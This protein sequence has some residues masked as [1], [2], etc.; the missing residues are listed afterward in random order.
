MKKLISFF[1]IA[2][3]FVSC[4]KDEEKPT[5]C[6]TYQLKNT[7]SISAEL[8]KDTV[9]F[10]NC[11]ENATRYKWDFGDGTTSTEENPVHLYEE[12]MP[13]L[14]SLT[15]YNG[16]NSSVLTDTIWD[17][18]IVFKP[19]IYLYPEKTLELCVNLNFPKGGHVVSSIPEYN[20]GWCIS[21][22]PSGQIDNE[23]G[24][25][26]Y[27]SA[28]PNI[29]QN[30]E[31]WIISQT[32]LSNFFNK[33]MQV[34]GFNSNEINDFIEYWIPLLN[35]AKTYAVYPQMNYTIDRVIELEFSVKPKNVNRLFYVIKGVNEEFMLNE[36]EIVSFNKNGFYVNEWG[37]VL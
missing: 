18:A 10:T 33:N 30:S 2:C 5:A 13:T 28:Q 23:Y 31:G 3:L 22:E 36:P 32:E 19:N 17:W 6:F 14:V 7:S 24:Y 8:T 37:V 1:C 4:N 16:S 25:L 29:W 26:F 15:A 21:V 34:Y 9:I 27:E 35:T 12:N 11:S 20:N